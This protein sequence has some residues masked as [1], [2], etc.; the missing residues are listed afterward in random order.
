MAGAT[1]ER[2]CGVPSWTERRGRTGAGSEPCGR[3]GAG[4]SAADARADLGALSDAWAEHGL[5]RRS[6]AA[7][8]ITTALQLRSSLSKD[9]ARAAKSPQRCYR[10]GR[11][12]CSGVP[13]PLS[14]AVLRSNAATPPVSSSCLLRCIALHGRDVRDSTRGGCNVSCQVMALWTKILGIGSNRMSRERLG[15]HAHAAYGASCLLLALRWCSHGT[16]QPAALKTRLYCRA[17][18]MP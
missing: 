16:S 14:G 5:N 13:P 3:G 11:R 12:C 17:M 9:T 18:T 15:R 6:A 1:S 8:T 4:G 7:I 10:Y 2:T